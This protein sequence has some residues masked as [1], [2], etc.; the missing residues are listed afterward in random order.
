M[1][2]F[3]LQTLPTSIRAFKDRVRFSYRRSYFTPVFNVIVSLIQSRKHLGSQNRRNYFRNAKVPNSIHS[4]MVY[5]P[6][7]SND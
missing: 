3:G 2:L 4:E 6:L 7:T 1:L 5:I